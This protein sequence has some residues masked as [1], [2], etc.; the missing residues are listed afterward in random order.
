MGFSANFLD[1]LRSRVSLAE[2]VGRRV[3]LLKRGR[4]HVGLCPFHNEKTPSFTVSDDK[5]FYH[6]FGCGAHGDVITFVQDSEGVGFRDAVERLAAA[7]G[8][9][10]PAPSPQ[11]ARE[12]SRRLTL[13]DAN[14]AAAHWFAE[15][16]RS[17]RGEAARAYLEKRGLK[18]GT[19]RDFGL[20]LA[21]NGRALMK[22]ALMAK[23]FDGMLLAEA[24]LLIKP[25]DGGD[26]F[27]RF[28]NRLMFPIRDRRGRVIAF[29]GRALD[30]APAKYLNSPETALF[31]KGATLYNLDKAQGPA[32]QDAA[33]IVAEG[34]MDVI[35]LAQ[36]GFPNAVAP[37][38]TALTEDQLRLL[39][40][41]AP[42]PVLCFDGDSA[43]ARA[44]WRAAERALPMLSPGQSLR[45]AL[46]PPGRDPDDLIRES[47]ADAMRGVI[48][49]AMPLADLVWQTLTK[50]AQTDTPERRAGLEKEIFTLLSSIG[51]PSLKRF[52]QQDMN[53]RL[54]ALWRHNT[55]E[56][57]GF[58]QRGQGRGGRAPR[59][60]S[61]LAAT[62]AARMAPQQQ[63]VRDVERVIL[64]TL[65]NHP[66]LAT[67][68]LEQ[69]GATHFAS[70][71]ID[72][73]IRSLLSLA[74]LGQPLDSQGVKDNLRNRGLGPLVDAIGR[75]PLFRRH[76]FAAAAAD[77]GKAGQG[78]AHCLAR[79]RRVVDLERER[80]AAEAELSATGNPEAWER[81]RAIQAALNDSD[82]L[83]ADFDH[84]G[85]S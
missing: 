64:A 47:G 84:A 80:A 41:L 42:E 73:A 58:F 1:E 10:I 15:Q 36:A 53:S 60:G 29:G 59:A 46:L 77:R 79:L 8:M 28:R 78:L 75:D 85:R 25:E 34:Y 66:D 23:G 33:V 72:K 21:P 7:A 17:A 61:L 6:C 68:H 9:A 76:G 44:A 82:G 70:S 16:L 12:E 18:E 38:G 24:G 39:W 43:G 50:D 71:D 4:E 69:L 56:K 51:D 74:S 13:I 57:K 37:L 63:L 19:V 52:Y 2:T 81:L 48:G 55:M 11:A 35:A 49:A 26:S 54:A 14:E 3:K 65:L 22:Q 20:G 40:R 30:D 62:S 32:R 83:E 27:D 5:G 31:H 45:F 67:D